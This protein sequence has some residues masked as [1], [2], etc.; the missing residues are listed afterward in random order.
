MPDSNVLLDVITD[1]PVWAAWSEAALDAGQANGIFFINQIIF[2]EISPPFSG[3]EDIHSFLNEGRVQLDD[4]S[5]DAAFLAG[6]AFRD[7]RARGGPRTSPLNDFFIGAHALL[8]GYTLITRDP[9][10][11]RAY[12]PNLKLVSP[13]P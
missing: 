8:R 11:Y 4:I 13:E 5:W 6:Q 3:I 1:D 10:R 2:A 12:F 9:R 7:Y